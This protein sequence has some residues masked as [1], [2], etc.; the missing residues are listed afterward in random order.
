MPTSCE[1]W[2]QITDAEQREDGRLL[3]PI[4]SPTPVGCTMANKDKSAANVKKVGRTPKE[5]KAAK[6]AKNTAQAE[7]RK[8]WEK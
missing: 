8:A 1:R 2:A 6:Q 3:R 5:K 7:T 4:A